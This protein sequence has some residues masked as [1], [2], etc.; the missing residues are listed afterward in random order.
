ME[1][2]P[3]VDSL[4]AYVSLPDEV[5]PFER[6]YLAK[7][8]RVAL[9]LFWAHAPLL[10]FVA[11]LAG[12]GVWRALLYSLVVLA[13]PTLAW[14]T[15]ENPRHVSMTYGVAAMCMGGLLVHFGQ[16]PMQIEMHFYFFVVIALLAVFANPRVVL[17]AALTATVHHLALFFLLPASIFNY[18]ATFWT[19]VVH[20][21]FVVAD[22]VAACFVARSFFDNVIGLDRMVGA[23]DGRNAD[24]RLVLENVGQGFV[25][26]DRTVAWRPSARPPSTAGSGRPPRPPSSPTTSASST[27]P[28]PPG[29]GSGSTRCSRT[30]SPPRWPST[31]CPAGSRAAAPPGSSAT[32]PSSS[33]AGSRRSSWSSPTSPSRSPRSARSWSAASSPS[34]S[35]APCATPTG[36]P[37][38]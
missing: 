13:G 36:S 21:A 38:S 23:L 26:I 35:S 17:A 27:P 28:S 29:S 10:M 1:R 25:T 11:G 4:M 14:R 3:K 34:C 31:R 15:F 30:S 16:G 7:L 12:T 6:R 33:R 37:S 8:N 18:S 22:S 19:V 20:A 5:T 9:V 2:M 24:L 32:A